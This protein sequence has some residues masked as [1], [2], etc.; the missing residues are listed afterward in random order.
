MQGVEA[1][2]IWQSEVDYGSW[3]RVRRELAERRVR[4]MLTMNLALDALA[5]AAGLRRP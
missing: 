4:E 3:S 2:G 5:L 1:V